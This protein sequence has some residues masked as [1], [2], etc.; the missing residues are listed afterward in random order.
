MDLQQEKRKLLVKAEREG[1]LV[2]LKDAWLYMRDNYDDW[3]F[4]SSP[5]NNYLA[6]NKEESTILDVIKKI[7]NPLLTEKLYLEMLE[8]V[9]K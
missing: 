9:L 2:S 4:F 7:G 8:V 6:N 5:I 3:H 1:K